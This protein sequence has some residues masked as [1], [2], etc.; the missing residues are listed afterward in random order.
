[1][2]FILAEKPKAAYKIAKFLS[3]GRPK[4]KIL[5]NLRYFEFQREGKKFVCVPILGHLFK[6]DTKNKKWYYP[7]FNVEWY[8]VFREKGKR[9]LE[10]YLEALRILARKSSD[11]IIAT[12]YDI[13]GDVIGYNVLRFVFRRNN[14]KRMKFSS[15]TKRDIEKAFS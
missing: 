6:L 12:D 5:K 9:R 8:P 3:K 10:K 1:M 13:E 14:A 4:S 2:I 15:L 11:I 7:I